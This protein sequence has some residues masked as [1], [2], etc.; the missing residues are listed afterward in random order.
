MVQNHNAV[1]VAIGEGSGNPNASQATP[2]N[3][4]TALPS[5]TNTIGGIVSHNGFADTATPLTSSATFTGTG[6]Q[7]FY[8]T[9]FGFFGAFAY[10]DVAGTLYI[11][12]SSDSGTT[13][14]E[15][16]SAPL[17]AGTVGYRADL[18]VRLRGFAGSGA[19]YYRARFVNG[20]TAQTTFTLSTSFTVA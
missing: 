18:N 6:R 15:A 4:T 12:H 14:R 10:S 7:T 9:G 2:V 3:V 1:Q 5:G 8:Y 17:V 20:G 13:W 11:D 16:A 19:A